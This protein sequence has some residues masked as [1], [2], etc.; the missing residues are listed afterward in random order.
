MTELLTVLNARTPE[1]ITI[2][3]QTLEDQIT[4]YLQSPKGMK[5]ITIVIPFFVHVDNVLRKKNAVIEK[6]AQNNFKMLQA[7]TT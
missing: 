1:T 4:P 6:T 3:V 2:F 5:F 7:Q